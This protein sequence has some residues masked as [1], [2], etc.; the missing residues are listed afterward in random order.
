MD[1]LDEL[2]PLLN[3]RSGN[4]NPATAS[5]WR[6]WAE[7]A[8]P[9]LLEYFNGMSGERLRH[10]R[11]QY[12]AECTPGTDTYGQLRRDCVNSLNR[13][14]EECQALYDSGDLDLEG[15]DES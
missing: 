5:V 10:V 3:D 1:D 7:H 15:H 2:D 9:E 12:P 14:A 13:L 11:R 4:P 6:S 8:S